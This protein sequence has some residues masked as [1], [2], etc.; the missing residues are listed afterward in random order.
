MTA[1]AA[2]RIGAYIALSLCTG[3][4]AEEA[5]ALPWD[6]VDF[7]DPHATSHSARVAV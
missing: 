3:I 1:S 2:T 7:R 5:R 6:S 4:R